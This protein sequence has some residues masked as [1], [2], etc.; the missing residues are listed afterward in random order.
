MIPPFYDI[1]SLY[2]ALEQ[3]KESILCLK[4]LLFVLPKTTLKLNLFYSI[5]KKEVIKNE[6]RRF[7]RTFQQI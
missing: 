2:R 5:Y 1:L 6:H 7:T 3:Q 4:N